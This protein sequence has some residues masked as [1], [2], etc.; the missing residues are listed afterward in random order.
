MIRPILM[1]FSLLFSFSSYGAEEESARCPSPDTRTPLCPTGSSMILDD[2]YPTSAVVISN[3]TAYKNNNSEKTTSNFIMEVINAYKDNLE[4]MPMIIVP[5]K[6]CFEKI[7]E[8]LRSQ[9]KRS[10]NYRDNQIESILFKVRQSKRN[11]IHGNRTI[12]SF[13]R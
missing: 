9:I 8:Q 7:R 4:N 3:Q 5:C 6:D 1:T 11:L 10:V 13:C 12:L 2:T